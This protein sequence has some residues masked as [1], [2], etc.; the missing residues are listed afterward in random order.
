LDGKLSA[1]IQFFTIEIL[2]KTTYN[3][4]LLFVFSIDVCS[5][6]DILYN[7]AVS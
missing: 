6:G 5:Q 2:S 4:Y 1:K 7:F 3:G